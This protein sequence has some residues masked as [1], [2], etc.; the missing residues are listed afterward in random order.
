MRAYYF[1]LEN[2]RAFQAISNSLFIGRRIFRL[3]KPWVAERVVKLT[4]ERTFYAQFPLTRDV[5]LGV[6]KF[7]EKSRSHL[8]ILDMKEVPF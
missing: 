4:K 1:T 2:A 8:L 7:S 6:H 5:R 3:Y